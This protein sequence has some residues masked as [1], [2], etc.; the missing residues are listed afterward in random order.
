MSGGATIS[1]FMIFCLFDY[2]FTSTVNRRGLVG[3][4]SYLYTIKTAMT[5]TLPTVSRQSADLSADDRPIK[6]QI[7]ALFSSA[8][9]K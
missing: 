8:D 6:C 7:L 3:T 5:L 9:K 4:V 2:S 1:V